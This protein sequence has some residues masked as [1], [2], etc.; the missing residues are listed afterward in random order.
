MAPDAEWEYGPTV[1]FGAGQDQPTRFMDRVRDPETG[2]W[3]TFRRPGDAQ[4]SPL[5][6]EDRGGPDTVVFA[7]LDS[8]VVHDHPDIAA[9]QVEDEDLTGEGPEDLHG[10]GTVVTLIYLADSRDGRR[11]LNVKIA[12]RSGNT[13]PERIIQGLGKVTDY[14]RAHPEL[15]VLANISGGTYSRRR[16]GLLACDGTCPVCD[17]ARAAAEA[18]VFVI[19]AAGNTR[20]TTAC[21]AKAAFRHPKLPILAVAQA[22]YAD[23]GVGT[24]ATHIDDLPVPVPMTPAPPEPPGSPQPPQGQIVG[25]SGAAADAFLFQVADQL[26]DAGDLAQTERVYRDLRERG[27][28]QATR[29][30]ATLALGLVLAADGRPDEAEDLLREAAHGTEEPDVR[31][32]ALYSWGRVAAEL[33][34]PDAEQRFRETI[35][36]GH[37]HFSPLAADYLATELIKADHPAEALSYLD[38]AVEVDDVDAAGRARYNRAQVLRRLGRTDEARA[39]FLAVAKGDSAHRHGAAL[40]LGSLLAGLGELDEAISWIT[41]ATRAPEP[42]TAALAELG[43]GDIAAAVDDRE[44]AVEHHQRA[45]AS[46][47]ADVVELARQRLTAARR[48]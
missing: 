12:D 5:P 41:L 9:Q 16:F 11:V 26:Q 32:Q 48:G 13:T 14:Q 29:G 27:H 6:G 23:S 24:I 33:G 47:V 3:F 36:L 15:G 43:L 19:T 42:R 34:R 40:S 8:G 31:A 21:P 20:G 46:G 30:R 39:D 10:H 45:A 28:T 38:R 18:G 35:A 37:R 4:A 44:T 2:T 17:A 1:L 7:V 25:Y 22:G